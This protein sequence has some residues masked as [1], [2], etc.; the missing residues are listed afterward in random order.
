MNDTLTRD[1]LLASARK[2]F[3]NKGFRGA[4]VREI[5]HAAGANLGAVTYHF[6]SKEAL[7]TE[8]LER[9][10]GD[11]ASEAERVTT[12]PGTQAQ[13]LRA[14]VRAL[15]GFFVR[16]PEAPALVLHQVLAGAAP[17]ES[18]LSHMR[19]ILAVVQSVVREGQ[20]RGEFRDVD[21]L[22]VGFSII[23]QSAWFAVAGRVMVPALMAGTD[24]A[25]VAERIE[26]HISDLV[27]RAIALEATSP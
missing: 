11:L 18:I 3:A 13:R 17:P 19:R 7:H 27:C 23:S 15:F 14:V 6:G 12:A 8:V 25:V 20:A 24:H 26:K 10:F 2:L 16:A 9:F 4:T 5:T 1:R 22:L 21:P